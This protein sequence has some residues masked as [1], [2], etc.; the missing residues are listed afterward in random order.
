MPI[1]SHQ[2]VARL[3]KAIEQSAAKP[4]DVNRRLSSIKSKLEDWFF[5]E[6]EQDITD[7]FELF[8][9]SGIDDDDPLVLQASSSKGVIHLLQALKIRLS[10]S[11]VDCEPLRKMMGKIDTSIK[12][13]SS[14]Q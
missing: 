9:Y 11:Y 5:S 12:L 7:T 6:Y 14:L 2:F 4:I 8:Y 10:E 1:E 13:T 3:I